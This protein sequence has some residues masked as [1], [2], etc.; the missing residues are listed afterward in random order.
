MNKE[1]KRGFQLL[2]QRDNCHTVSSNVIKQN[3]PINYLWLLRYFKLGQDSFNLE[4]IYIDSEFRVTTCIKYCNSLNIDLNVDYLYDLERLSSE[5]SEYI[6]KTNYW[7][8][9]GYILIGNLDE[10]NLLFL[11]LNQEEF[12]HICIYKDMYDKE[13][14]YLML[15]SDILQFINN[16]YGFYFY[17]ENIDP[18]NLYKNWNEDF[19]RIKPPEFRDA[20]PYELLDKSTLDK[21]YLEMKKQGIDMIE[22]E[23]EYKVRGFDWPK[24]FFNW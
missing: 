9:D 15:E 5:I 14:G 17:V 13:L 18:S 21:K 4:K 1:F 10:N 12:G 23:Y 20:R 24:S 22:I 19:W 16:L 6:N 11:N 8:L 7:H 3:L 2:I